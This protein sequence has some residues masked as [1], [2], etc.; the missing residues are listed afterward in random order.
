MKR[1]IG[2]IVVHGVGAQEKFDTLKSFLRG[3]QTGFEHLVPREHDEY[4]ELDL[5]DRCIRF[6]E[7]FWADELK[8]DKT[9]GSFK[10]DMLPVVAW[11]PYLNEKAGWYPTGAYRPGHGRLWTRVLKLLMV[12]LWITLRGAS[13]AFESLVK[14]SLP[15]A[16][17]G[18]SL[19]ETAGDVFNYVKSR[20]NTHE[21]GSDFGLVAQ[22]ICDHFYRK[23][24]QALNDKCSELQV[25]AH[26]LGA[27]VAFD[28]LT[29]ATLPMVDATS[30][31]SID[32][33]S[34]M[35]RLYTFGSPLEK[36][37][38][39][40]PRLLLTTIQGPTT[41]SNEGFTRI[42]GQQEEKLPGN[43]RWYNFHHLADAVAGKLTHFDHWTQVANYRLKAMGGILRSHS[44]YYWDP[45]VHAIL[46]TEL[47][48]MSPRSPALGTRVR[49]IF[50]RYLEFLVAAIVGTV[51]FLIGL[52]ITGTVLL[53][54]GFVLTLPLRLVGRYDWIDPIAFPIAI[55]FAVLA[56]WG[57][58]RLARR[59]AAKE[60]PKYASPRRW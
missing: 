34:N 6:Y 60:H 19:D 52:G 23:I 27:V 59:N 46:G 15:A 10:F 58:F 43:F 54:P 31:R 45:Q 12:P 4:Y 40:W 33:F 29:G 1:C 44:L 17:L 5:P 50:A 56:G 21:P 37:L 41:E 22:K 28:S 18:A 39:F 51:L 53:L 55:V 32:P 9:H 14:P 7:V 13:F 36:I 11:F 2:V 25:V 35:T 49:R 16:D 8:G 38:F 24:M 57:L 20:A 30:S 47:L 26:S 3:L 42:S 48:G